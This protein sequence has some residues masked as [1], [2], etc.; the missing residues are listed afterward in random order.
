MKYNKVETPEAFT[1]I[2][3]EVIIET[4]E[5]LESLGYIC[6]TIATDD[7]DHEHEYKHRSA[8]IDMAESIYFA[9]V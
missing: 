8:L 2:T 5:D 1:P 3:V 6:A 4:A 7:I 9:A